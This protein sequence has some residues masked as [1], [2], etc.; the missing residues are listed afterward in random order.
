MDRFDLA[1]L[2]S[3]HWPGADPNRI[4]PTPEEERALR[5]ILSR[6]QTPADGPCPYCKQN[7]CPHWDG[8][9]WTKLR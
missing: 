3:W 5:A 4:I 8:M 2:V 9:G 7:P 6:P 1:A